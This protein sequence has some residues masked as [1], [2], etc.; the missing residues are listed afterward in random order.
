MKNLFTIL[1]GIMYLSSA[2]GQVSFTTKVLVADMP[3]TE[4]VLQD[5]GEDGDLDIIR[6]MFNDDQL[7]LLQNVGSDQPF[8]VINISGNFFSPRDLAIGDFDIDGKSDF[9]VMSTDELEVR[10]YTNSGWSFSPLEGDL[11]IEDMTVADIDNDGDDDI[12]VITYWG[13]R[14]ERLS[15]GGGGFFG[16]SRI[17]ND[18][19]L[20]FKKVALGEF[21]GDDMLD[22]IYAGDNGI[23]MIENNNDKTFTEI[24]AAYEQPSEIQTLDLDADGDDDIL[25][26]SHQRNEIVW[27]EFDAGTF[28]KRMISSASKAAEVLHAVDIESDGDMDFFSVASAE[29]QFVWW[30][31]DGNQNFTATVIAGGFENPKDITSADMDGDGDL[32]LIGCTAGTDDQRIY[33]LEHTQD[34]VLGVNE[35]DLF[36]IEVSPNPATTAINITLHDQTKTITS[37]ELLDM[38][39]KSIF[40]ANANSSKMMIPLEVISSGIYLLKVATKD[41]FVTEKVIVQK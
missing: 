22:Y 11:G 31:N 18:D 15:N 5:V 20:K 1:C 13:E 21:N 3:A 26:T 6:A 25:V 2:I 36:E 28:T 38:E 33:L 24:D 35:S 40:Q 32:D 39:N 23:Y 12:V 14:V 17:Y 8:E 16:P 27:Y 4:V 19:Q 9:A 7:T 29:G 37:V 10:V 34:F 41:G 30:K